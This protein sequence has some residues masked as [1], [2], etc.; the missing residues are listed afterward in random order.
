MLVRPFPQYSLSTMASA[1]FPPLVV[2]AASAAGGTSTGKNT[3]FHSIT[4][5]FTSA[6]SVRLLDFTLSWTLVRHRGLRRFLFVGPEI[7]YRAS[8]SY[9]I[10]PTTLRF[11]DSSLQLASSGLHPTDSAHAEHT[12]NGGGREALPPPFFC[13]APPDATC[14]AWCPG[15]SISRCL[16]PW[17]CQSRSQPGRTCLRS[18]R[19]C[20]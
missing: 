13:T 7:C 10:A 14:S 16:W 4:A 11:A 18:R 3:D 5:V 19:I 2:T 8:F 12:R 6:A 9:W 20:T 1:D 15:S 17:P